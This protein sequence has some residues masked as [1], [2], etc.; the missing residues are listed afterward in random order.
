MVD[1]SCTLTG[2]H[3]LKFGIDFRRLSPFIQIK[4]SIFNKHHSPTRLQYG[5]L[6]RIS[7]LVLLGI[8]DAEP[9]FMNFSAFAQDT[10]RTSQRLTLTYGLRWEINPAPRGA[11]GNDAYTATGMD[12]PATI[13]LAPRGTPLYNTR[14]LNFAPRFGIAYMFSQRPGL[15]TVLRGGVGV[16][17]DM[18]NAQS[19]LGFTFPPFSTAILF[20]NRT[21][22]IPRVKRR[23]RRRRFPI[24]LFSLLRRSIPI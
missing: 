1:T 19:T 13:T 15:E 7:T 6:P 5:T 8:R 16:F 10:W 22:L 3:Q 21:F 18:G 9:R 14:Y 17:Y 24:L 12:N 20:P 11:D 4:Q 23:S 2:E